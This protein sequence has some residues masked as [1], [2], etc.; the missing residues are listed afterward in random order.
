MRHLIL[1]AAAVSLVA[2]AP[3]AEA[4]SLSSISSLLSNYGLNVT[5]PD[6]EL[7]LPPR[8]A[9]VVDKVYD[10]AESTLDRLFG[11]GGPL[12]DI[13]FPDIDLSHITLPEINLP[14]IYTPG[15]PEIELPDFDLPDLDQIREDV[16]A[17][18]DA[19]KAKAQVRIDA[20]RDKIADR[21]ESVIDRIEDRFPDSDLPGRLEDLI[22]RAHGVLDDILDHETTTASTLLTS[23]SLPPVAVEAI[24]SAFSSA[25]VYSLP[26]SASVSIPEPTT[27]M[28]GA[29]GLLLAGVAR[30]RR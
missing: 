21:L 16:Q 11:E 10:R 24:Q 2:T 12:A 25:G 7:N 29:A 19:A 1:T 14:E 28:L 26:V 13:D 6:R 8:V 18:I 27:A 9:A 23:A 4:F 22:D 20:A 15:F 5:L 17:K 3:K 30:R